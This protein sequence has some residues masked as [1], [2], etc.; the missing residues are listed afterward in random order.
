MFVFE[1]V[2]FYLSFFDTR[3]IILPEGSLV[4]KYTHMNKIKEQMK[5]GPKRSIINLLTSL[6]PYIGFER[7]LT[8]IYSLLLFAHEVQFSVKYFPTLSYTEV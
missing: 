6:L 5:L 7:L 8:E 2:V 4:S 1:T 3:K